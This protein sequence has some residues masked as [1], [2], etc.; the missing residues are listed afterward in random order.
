MQKKRYADA[1]EPFRLLL[2]RFPNSPLAGEAQLSLAE[3]HAAEKEYAEAES[4][5]D[6]FLRL[7]PASDRVPYALFRKGEIL[8]RQAAPAG[9]D[10]SKTREALETFARLVRDHP[11]SPHAAP[12]RERIAALRAR[13]ADHEETVVRHYLGRRRFESA[14]LRARRAL[15]D[16][17][18]APAAPRLMAH[19]AAALEAQGKKDEATAVRRD[20]SARFPDFGAKK[21]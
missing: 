9:R 18:D 11:G 15:S 6:D 16:Y 1:V 21:R 5:F 20:L 13:L 4:A 2:E 19:L 3:A 7:Y 14:E 10:Q 17:P 12:A 8:M